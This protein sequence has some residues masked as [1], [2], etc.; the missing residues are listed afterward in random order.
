M[1]VGDPTLNSYKDK[2]SGPPNIHS[3]VLTDMGVQLKGL[4]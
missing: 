2:S 3:S 4:R 1:T